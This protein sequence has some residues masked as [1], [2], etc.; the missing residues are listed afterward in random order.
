MKFGTGAGDEREMDSWMGGEELSASVA[1]PGLN[2][3]R[4][5]VG[6]GEVGTTY[7]ISLDASSREL[8]RDTEVDGGMG[9]P[10]RE[11]KALRFSLTKN[12]KAKNVNSVRK[13]SGAATGKG[14]EKM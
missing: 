2:G 3:V 7:G 5:D 9:V 6:V 10:R 11:C 4:G 1:D 13:D 12:G 14:M 8:L